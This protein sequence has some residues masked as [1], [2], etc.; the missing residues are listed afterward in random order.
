MSLLLEVEF[1][2]GVYRGTTEPASPKA[3]WPPQPDRVFSALVSSWAIRGECPRERQALEWLEEQDPPKIHCSPAFPRTAPDVFVPP[4][5][6]HRSGNAGNYERVM[7]YKRRR[8][9]RHFPATCPISPTLIVEWATHPAAG[10]VES[11]QAIAQHVGYLGHSASLVRFRF[12]IGDVE[13]LPFRPTMAQRRIYRGRL[14]ELEAAHQAD[15]V[16]PLIRPGALVIPAM[17]QEATESGEWLVL[18]IVSDWRPDLL[19]ASHCCREVRQALMS[20]YR[21]IGE[22]NRI[23]EIVS[24][25]TDSGQPTVR[26]HLSIVP[27]AFVGDKHATAAIYGFGLVPPIGVELT[28]VPGLLQAFQKISP[29]DEQTERRVLSLRAAQIRLS[30]VS[31]TASSI[32]SLSP[33]LYRRSARCWATVTPIVLDRHLKTFSNAEQSELVAAACRNAGLPRPDSGSI[34][35]GQHSAISGAPS[36]QKGRKAPPWTKWRVPQHLRT[37]SLVHAVIDFREPVTGPVILGAGRFIG[38]G[39]CKALAR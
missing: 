10:V 2:T 29:Y 5:D 26:P 25:H 23:P 33:S 27:M 16:R 28:D 13:K 19:G 37:R 32:R 17:E 18:E 11:L 38:L 14:A 34:Q 12:D 7:P 15:P 6:D 8:Q 31:P 24:G 36:I 22:G 39:L 3:D 35:V 30:P 9:P 1:L 20:G 4:N 21:R